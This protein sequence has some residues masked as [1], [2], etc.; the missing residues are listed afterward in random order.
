MINEEHI[1][2]EAKKDYV[3]LCAADGRLIW[4]PEREG[5]SA[6]PELRR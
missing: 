3:L 5:P 2:V 4:P 6:L 1:V